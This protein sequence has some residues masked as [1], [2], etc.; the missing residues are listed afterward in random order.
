MPGGISY[1]GDLTIVESGGEI[2][3]Q[4][5]G[6]KA[7]KSS[8]ADG[9]SVEVDSTSGKLQLVSA[10]SSLSSGIQRA[11]MSKGAG[12]WFQGALTPS[13]AVAGVFQIENTFGSD[14]VVDRVIILITTASTLASSID[15]GVAADGVTS[16][17]NLLDGID[18]TSLGA[19]DNIRSM[20]DGSSGRSVM[21]WQSGEF[22]N[23]SLDIGATAGLVGFYA[24]HI[25]DLTS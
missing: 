22:I 10:G 12:A 14:L 24:V 16:A 13:D 4:A 1:I 18:G 11:Q 15:I 6:D 23:G 17:N 3:S 21:L 9:T 7:L 20:D 2:T 8:C 25:I 5:V 19:T